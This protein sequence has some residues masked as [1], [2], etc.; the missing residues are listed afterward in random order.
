ME[1]HISRRSLI[2]GTTVAA[3]AG[4]TTLALGQ[5]SAFATEDAK[6]L[7]QQKIGKQIDLGEI[8]IPT[9]E[10]TLELT[11]SQASVD[12]NEKI[13]KKLSRSQ[14]K[15]NEENR[16]IQEKLTYEFREEYR[17]AIQSNDLT[18]RF[19]QD[20]T[21]PGSSQTAASANTY[22][23]GA[24]SLYY[25]KNSDGMS[26]YYSHTGILGTN[27]HPLAHSLQANWSRGRS[28]VFDPTVQGTWWSVWRY[29]DTAW[30]AFP[31]MRG[32]SGGLMYSSVTKVE[33][34]N[35]TM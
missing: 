13:L 5:N 19:A 20:I 4:A 30:H 34:Y 32:A 7:T 8:Y 17:Q 16:K 26:Y 11:G 29:K 15:K 22:A 31:T 9:A 1:N 2:Q 35:I 24:S 12:S 23:A 18:A 33:R 6:Q 27:L 28:F 10:E 21:S 25:V 3:L 14:A